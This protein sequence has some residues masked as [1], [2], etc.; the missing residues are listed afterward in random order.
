[1]FKSLIRDL[2]LKIQTRR[3][4]SRALFVWAAVVVLAC[5]TAFIFLCIALYG[6]LSL[7]L[8]GV[9]AGLVVVGIFLCIAGVG[10]IHLSLHRPLRVAVATIRRSHRRFGSRGHLHS[11]CGDR[12]NHMRADES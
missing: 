1:M 6:W 9:I 10:R 5:L 3:G 4:V 12:R 7:Q 8:G 11:D 2:P